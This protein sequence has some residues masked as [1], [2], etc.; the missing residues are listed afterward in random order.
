M[1]DPWRQM[2]DYDDPRTRTSSILEVS[3]KDLIL[4]EDTK[5]GIWLAKDRVPRAQGFVSVG[6]RRY[7]GGVGSQNCMMRPQTTH[8]AG[9]PTVGGGTPMPRMNLLSPCVPVGWRVALFGGL[10][11]DVD[12]CLEGGRPGG[13]R[14]D[15]LH[16][17]GR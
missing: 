10:G 13:P 1:D 7:C 17:V 9:L 2:G 3:D 5:L 16:S 12:V 6:S 4:H 8:C 11:D 15:M 14:V